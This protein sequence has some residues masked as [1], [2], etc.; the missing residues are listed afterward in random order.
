VKVG[1]PVISRQQGQAL[2]NEVGALFI[3]TSAKEG[4]NIHK[5]C[6]DLIRYVYICID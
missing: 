6:K 4:S 3:E 1:M 5:A 2:A